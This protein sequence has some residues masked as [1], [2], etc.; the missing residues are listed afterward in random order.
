MDATVLWV[1]RRLMLPNQ[2]FECSLT[3]NRKSN[4]VDA[5]GTY[6][7]AA[8]SRPVRRSIEWSCRL[9]QI[10]VKTDLKLA[11]IPWMS[12]VVLSDERAPS[13]RPFNQLSKALAAPP[14]SFK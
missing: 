11:E 13:S 2:G 6:T 14:V 7:C 5:L 3:N 10:Q 8:G 9:R 1:T 4:A 12:S